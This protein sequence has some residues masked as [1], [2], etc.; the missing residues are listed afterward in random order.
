MGFNKIHIDKSDI[1]SKLKSNKGINY[2][3]PLVREMKIDQLFSKAD[4]VIT[5]SWSAKFLKD[6]NP[7]EREIRENLAKKHMLDSGPFFLRDA[8]Y[9]NLTSLS[10]CLIS[11]MTSGS[12]YFYHHWIDINFAI[13]KLGIKVN[14]D[15]DFE[16]LKEK[17][18]NAIIKYFDN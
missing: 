17:C 14:N 5:D 12:D 13:E 2:T 4:A 15:A 10:E 11:L 16:I 6:L 7:K 8:D 18:I 9:K 1:L 3:T